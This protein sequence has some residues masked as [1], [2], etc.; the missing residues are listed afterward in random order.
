MK[1]ALKYIFILSIIFLFSCD[2]STLFLPC[3]G[4]TATE[5][6]E[7]VLEIKV[8]G[9]NGKDDVYGTIIRIYD[10]NLEDDVLLTSFESTGLNLTYTA[11]ISKKYTFTATY[12]INGSSYTTVDSVEPVTI[13]EKDKC[14]DPC[15]FVLD[16]AVDLRLKY[17]K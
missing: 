8:Q 17:T 4:C 12:F 7:A 5:P 13:Y 2:K 6:T 11:K 10:G 3:S 1:S 16:K 14:T 9:P 15:Y